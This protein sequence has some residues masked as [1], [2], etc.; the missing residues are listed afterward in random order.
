MTDQPPPGRSQLAYYAE[1]SQV[2]VEIAAP[3]GLG[4]WLDGYLG[5]SPW[6]VITG[7]LLGFVGGMAHLLAI[8]SRPEPPSEDPHDP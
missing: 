2:G 8:V 7:T 4:A 1:L 3:I 6:L 5:W